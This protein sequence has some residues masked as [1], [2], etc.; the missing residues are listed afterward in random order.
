MAT[1]LASFYATYKD[2]ALTGVTNLDEAPLKV[3]TA[4]LPCK[5]ID[6]IGMD[7]GPLRA[8]GAGG[9][10]TL[11]G[12]VVV[13]V[14]AAGQD[15]HTNRWADALA[16]VDTLNAGIKAAADNST[17]WSADVVPDFAGYFAVVA[18]ITTEEWTV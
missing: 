5:W 1:T 2:M 6:S 17:S 4:E 13:A 16:M 8:K 11:R 9:E 14:A 7:E 12:R 10:R 3:T 15:T 18:T